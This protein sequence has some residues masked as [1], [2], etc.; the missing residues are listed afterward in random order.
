M[1]IAG[2]D[3]VHVTDRVVELRKDTPAYRRATNRPGYVRVRGEPGMDRKAL[4]ERAVE[5]AQEN[6]A[7]LAGMIARQYAPDLWKLAKFQ[8]KQVVMRRVFATP[9][10]PEQRGVMKP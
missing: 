7:K 8:R 10:D 6:D 2:W 3:L 1:R 5:L 4:I 9:E